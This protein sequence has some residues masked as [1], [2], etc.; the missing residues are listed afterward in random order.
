MFQQKSEWGDFTLRELL[1]RA[2]KYVGIN[3]TFNYDREIG[4]SKTLRVSRYIDLE[5]SNDKEGQHV[6]T[7]YYDK[8]ISTSKNLVSQQD[9]V[10]EILPLTSIETEFSQLTTE[11]GGFITSNDIYFVSSGIIH[12]PNLE[13]VF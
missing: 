4:Y 2:F 6:S 5:Q 11:N 13:V 8:V 3:P 10:R 12:T 9:F 7:D 1:I